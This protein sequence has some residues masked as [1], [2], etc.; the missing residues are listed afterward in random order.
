MGPSTG[1]E[2]MERRKIMPLPGH[3]LLPLG[4]PGHSQSLCRLRDSGSQLTYTY[5][6]TSIVSTHRIDAIHGNKRLLARS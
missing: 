6:N 3:E 4:R 5:Q 1:L 2:H